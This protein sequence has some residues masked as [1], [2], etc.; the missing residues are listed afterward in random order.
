MKEKNFTYVVIL[1]N[2]DFIKTDTEKCSTDFYALISSFGL[3]PYIIHPSEVV[4]GN[5]PSLIDNI[6]SNNIADRVL[7]GN[8][9][10]QLSEHFSQFASVKRDRIDIQKIVMYGRDWSKY[11]RDK[12]R[13]EISNHQWLIDSDDPSVLM[14]DF[15]SKLGGSADQ[16]VK[17]KKLSPR[18]IKLKL[19]PWITPEIKKML[20]LRDRLFARKKREPSNQR[21]EQVY[22]IARN[23]VSR[24]IQKSKQEYQDAYFVEHQNDIKKTWEGLR[25]LLNMKKSVRFSIS[26]LNVNGVIVDDP[27][28]IA[29]K[30]NKFFVNVGPETEK[31]VPKVPNAS[32]EKYLKNRNQFELIIAHISEEEILNI[33]NALPN[34]SSGPTSIPL[35]LLQDASDIIITP[36]CHIINLSLSTG[37]FPDIL[38]ITKVVAIHK[39]GSTQELNNFRPISLLSIFDKIIEKLIHKRVYEFFEDHNILYE[40][41]FGFRKKMSTGHSLVEI[42]EEIKESI[43]NGK[44]GCGIFIDLKKAFDTVNH[45]ILLT[46][47]EHYG[48]R[49]VLLKWFES[50]L[51]NRR[52]YVYHN[53][54]AS[55]MEVITCG[56]PQG[57]VLGPLLFLIYVNDLP[58]ISDKLRFFLFADDTNIYYDSNDLVELEKTVNQELR[59]LSQWLNINRLALNVGKTNFVIFRANRRIYHNVTLILNRKAIEQKDHVKYLGVL[60]DEHL[61]WKNQI[62]NVTKK[63]SRGVG[64]LAKLRSYLDPKL[65]INIYYCIVFSHLSYGVEAWGSACATDLEQILILQKKAVRILTGNRYFQIH[66]EE[67]A[68]L[69]RS[70]PLFKTLE[71]LKFEDIFKVSIGKFV[72]S[73][74][75]KENP[76]VFWEWFTYSHL[77]HNHATS[78]STNVVRTHYFDVGT[79][80]QTKFLFT[81]RSHLLNYGGKMIQV[82]G[83]ILWNSLPK[84]IHDSP[85]LS[86]FKSRIKNYYVS[87]YDN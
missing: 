21:V 84:E 58:N 78:S 80:E 65:L 37:I 6:F 13:D 11:D 63:I 73:T 69:P 52:Q 50:Y 22:K 24:K 70:E 40:L 72:Y 18:E 23:R 32:P 45:Q 38:K 59:K 14:S 4:E 61:N 60:M 30:L 29:E 77:I 53:G 54:I 28:M 10:M 76:S 12:F 7:S 57:S 56:V 35:R 79:V 81:K 86:T 62:A 26:Q 51:T 85:S 44:F 34:K 41:Q 68:A 83:P 19:N 75:A 67:A 16:H 33:I 39:G 8:I 48:I 5:I 15:Y 9:Y 46:K 55:D 43:D 87:L 64:I 17:I 82:Y 36:L 31:K 71:I 3:L 1:I 42:T 47:L 49:G 20:D 2:I 66:G 27:A 74:L 25:K